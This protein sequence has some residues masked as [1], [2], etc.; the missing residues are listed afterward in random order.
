LPIK[1]VGEIEI[2]R[3]KSYEKLFSTE[4]PRKITVRVKE[5]Y[6]KSAPDIDP[7]LPSLPLLT[8]PP[9][10]QDCQMV[11]FQTKILI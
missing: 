1:N 4:I 6:E 3:V 11:Y 10:N 8:F 5:M 7:Q 9:Q 2:F